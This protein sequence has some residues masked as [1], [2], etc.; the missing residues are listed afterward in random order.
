MTRDVLELRGPAALVHPERFGA[1]ALIA[2][3]SG[4]AR[5]PLPFSSQLLMGL[6]PSSSIVAEG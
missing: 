1:P 3:G 6:G 4:R 2:V 5:S